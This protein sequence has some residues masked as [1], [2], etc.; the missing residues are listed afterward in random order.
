[1]LL[2]PIFWNYLVLGG[3]LL[4]LELVTTALLALFLASAAFAL[5]LLVYIF[6]DLSFMWQLCLYSLLSL[7]SVW[8]WWIYH[9][10]HPPQK[11]DSASL[12]N[13]RAIALIG[14][15]IT[16]D[17]AVL[18]HRAR[19]YIDD[20]LWTIQGQDFAQG[21]TVKIIDVK[22]GILLVQKVS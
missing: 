15:E 17:Q 7:I 9:R 4:A 11:T 1:M 8:L 10:R 6:P 19:L 18:H 3:V 21:D 20:S 12:L 14:R 16:V 2:E 5:A 13:N 22:E